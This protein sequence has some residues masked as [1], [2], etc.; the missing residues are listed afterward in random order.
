MSYHLNHH[1]S[2][3]KMGTVAPFITTLSMILDME[4]DAIMRWSENGKYVQ[5]VNQTLLE[6]T[7]LLKYFRHQKYASFQRQLNYFGFRKQNGSR[8]LISNYYHKNFSRDRRDQWYLVRRTMP[9]SSTK[10]APPGLRSHQCCYAALE[11][12]DMGPRGGMALMP[13][14]DLAPPFDDDMDWNLIHDLMSDQ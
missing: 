10:M 14:L 2:S 8:A 6:D 9:K 13:P 11:V 1:C 5:I 7:V 3:M 12:N 4:D